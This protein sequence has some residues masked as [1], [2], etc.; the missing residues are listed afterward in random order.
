MK[1]I[2]SI[3]QIHPG[4]ASIHGG[5]SG[6]FCLHARDRLED[7]IKRYIELG[8]AWVGITEH[9]P[10]HGEKFRYPD[11]VEANL[12]LAH[13]LETF[14]A[15]IKECNRLKQKYR[16]EITIFTAFETETCSGYETFVQKMTARHR[17]DYI[18][19]SVHH[20]KDLGFDFSREQYLETAAILG[21]IDALYEQYFDLQYEMLKTLDPAVVGHFDLVR[22]FD[23]NY[24]STMKTPAIWQKIVRNLEC[25]K[26]QDIVMD[27]NL[28]ALSKGSSEPYISAPILALAKKMDIRVVPGD[29]SHCVTDVG[30]NM[31][32]AIDT[33]QKFGFD[34]LFHPPRLY[35]WKQQTTG[36][37]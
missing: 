20:V 6:Q 16:G 32:R 30:N 34:T 15:Y 17:P 1:K 2:Q 24:A 13:M 19:G 22:L 37:K 14:D 33:L 4:S 29:D 8:F 10:A 9:V 36:K 7:I 26:Q 31:P 11:E 28:R 27:Y 21:G 3:H 5:H 12:T 18:I 35:H 23:D 25:I